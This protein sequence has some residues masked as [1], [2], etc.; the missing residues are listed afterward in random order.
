MIRS[1][2]GAITACTSS[3]SLR[4]SERHALSAPVVLGLDN[5]RPRCRS[6]STHPARS[7]RRVCR[8]AGATTR[9]Y[10]SR[11]HLCPP[12]NASKAGVRSVTKT[13]TV[14]GSLRSTRARRTHGSSSTAS[15]TRPVDINRRFLPAAID[16]LA[17]TAERLACL[18]P[19]TTTLSTASQGDQNA[20]HNKA[21]AVATRAA[22][23]SRRFLLKRAT[24]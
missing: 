1:R 24:A 4:G 21:I 22:P 10:A 19:I 23:T 15:C 14:P 6:A 7:G 17:V 2:V 13:L 3:F 16:A 20:T 5:R 12:D 11:S 9:P 8:G 18:V